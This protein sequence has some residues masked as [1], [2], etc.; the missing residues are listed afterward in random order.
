MKDFERAKEA[1]SRA[2]EID[3]ANGA[4]NSKLFFNRGLAKYRLNSY[5]DAIKD[6]H[7]ALVINHCYGKA[8]LLCGHCFVEKK[9]FDKAIVT[10]NQAAEYKVDEEVSNAIA[11]AEHLLARWKTDDYFVLGLIR[12]ATMQEV[13]KAMRKL[14]KIYHPDRFVDEDDKISHQEVFKR[15]S[16]AKENLVASMDPDHE[17][18]PDD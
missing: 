12:P 17:W 8:L 6:F 14:S 16:E 7:N 11:N 10:Y 9:M 1:Y 5:D 13:I 3:P 15:I 18:V 4:I 2:L